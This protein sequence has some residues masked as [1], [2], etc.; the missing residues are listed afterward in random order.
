MSIFER[1]AERSEPKVG[2]AKHLAGASC[3]AEFREASSHRRTNGAGLRRCFTAFSMT[4]E[5]FTTPREMLGCADLRFAALCMTALFS[6]L[7]LA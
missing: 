1:H 2:A 5:W 4:D 3:H 7:A 6:S